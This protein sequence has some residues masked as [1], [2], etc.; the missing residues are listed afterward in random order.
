MTVARELKLTVEER[1]AICH[2]IHRA[3]LLA[4]ERARAIE[5]L[6]GCVDLTEVPPREQLN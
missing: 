6:A 5:I 2:R 1:I 3:P 4:D